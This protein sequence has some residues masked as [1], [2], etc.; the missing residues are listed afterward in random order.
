MLAHGELLISQHPK[1]LLPRATLNSFSAL[2]VFSLGIAP[3]QMQNLALGP[4]DLHEV[5]THLLGR[6][7]YLGKEQKAVKV[8][9]EV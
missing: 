3:V 5:C 9:T 1:V 7:I 6:C 2:P 8:K 4:V